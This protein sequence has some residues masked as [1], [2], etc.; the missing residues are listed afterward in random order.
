[1][2]DSVVKQVVESQCS[3]QLESFYHFSSIYANLIAEKRMRRF[4]N[5]IVFDVFLLCERVVFSYSGNTDV[6]A[7]M[8]P[9]G[10]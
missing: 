5:E 8:K 7:I 6:K 3:L 4:M 10:R 2:N 9:R 1:M